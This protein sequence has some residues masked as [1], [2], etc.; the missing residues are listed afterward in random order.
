MLDAI[1][2]DR[3]MAHSQ[4]AKH[5]RICCQISRFL[6]YLSCQWNDST[7]C[8]T[9]SPKFINLVVFNFRDNSNSGLNSNYCIFVKNEFFENLYQHCCIINSESC[10][11]RKW[12]SLF[13]STKF[14]SWECIPTMIDCSLTVAH[15][16][17]PYTPACRHCSVIEVIYSRNFGIL[18]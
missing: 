9:I 3:M 2:K 5:V 18:R 10:M 13:I 1:Q 6:Y 4:H 17:S 8:W 11:V 7:G 16:V 15:F 14:L 12:P